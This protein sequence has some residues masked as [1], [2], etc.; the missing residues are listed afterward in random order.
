LIG[1]WAVLLTALLLEV[2]DV[3]K[4]WR[5]HFITRL[6][7]PQLHPVALIYKGAAKFV[8]KGRVWRNTA[9]LL[10]FV[11]TPALLAYF[12]DVYIPQTLPGILAKAYFLKLTFSITQILYPCRKAFLKGGARS[13]VQEFVRRDLSNVDCRHVASACLETTAESFADSFISPLFWYMF[14]GLPGAW[15]QRAVN[16]LD[17]LMGFKEWGRSGAPAAYL[18]TVIVTVSLNIYNFF[19]RLVLTFHQFISTVYNTLLCAFYKLRVAFHHL[20][21]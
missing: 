1:N 20:R 21:T 16:I 19:L 6:I 3:P 9:V 10:I 7:P 14:L 15:L 11:I 8:K 2:V 4:L 12:V 5:G 18:D 17:G 13:V